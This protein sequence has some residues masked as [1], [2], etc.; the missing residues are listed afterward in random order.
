MSLIKVENLS[1]QF[2]SK[3]I[4]KKINFTISKGEIISIIGASGVGK[5]TLLRCLAMLEPFQGGKIIINDKFKVD[6][7]TKEKE[8]D[9]L[10]KKIGVVFQEFNLWPHKTTLENL[11][12]ALVLVKKMSK[13][14]A[15]QKAKT[16]LAKVDLLDKAE[17]YP[18]TLSGGQKQRVA[19]AR[20]L[21]M[22]PEIILLDEITAA[23]DPEL[24]AGVLKIIKRLAK[25]GTT[26]IVV[27][28][29]LRFAQEISDK[30]IF[31]DKGEI[32]EQGATELIFENP[33][34]ERTR[35]FLSEFVEKKQEINVYEGYQDFQAYHIGLLKRMKSGSTGYVVGAVGDRW[36]ECIG[37][38]Y[39]EYEQLLKKK[40]I[41]WK[42]VSYKVEDFEKEV[43]K[44]LGEQLQI[45][46]IPKKYSTP[47]NFNIWEDTII[48]QTFGEPPAVIEIKNEKLV[49]GYLNYF[50][51]L[52]DLGKKI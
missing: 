27:T 31:L 10:R 45:S 38:T 23:L 30:I 34:Q 47:S 32:V 18:D 26:M 24:A 20:T 35:I 52:W 28:H 46:L 2:S 25:E 22:Q 36:F 8:K 12:E 42:W 51:L 41:T 3:T 48:L 1:K 37:D 6:Q 44:R 21:I 9:K 19:I 13:D 50:N 11:V 33:K 7:T 39:P 5:T 40:N 49:S 29:H 4:L 16:W 15:I 14:K 43:K 17:E